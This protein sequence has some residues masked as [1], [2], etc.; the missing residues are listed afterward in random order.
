MVRIS[1]PKM[2]SP[3]GPRPRRSA[4]LVL[5]WMAVLVAVLVTT[6][7][8][9]TREVAATASYADLRLPPE[10]GGEPARAGDKVAKMEDE[11]REKDK[12]EEMEK[13]KRKVARMV[14]KMVP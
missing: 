11:S 7:Y 4:R 1:V 9:T 12:G 3:Y 8:L 13:E 10:V 5:V 6:F 2:Y 14:S